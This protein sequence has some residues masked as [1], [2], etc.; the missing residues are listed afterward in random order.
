MYCTNCGEKNFRDEAFCKKCGEKIDKKDVKSTPS[1]NER[2][3][4]N[5]GIL[6]TFMWWKINKEELQTQVDNYNALGITQSV[7]GIS[8][9]LLIFSAIVSTGSIFFLNT[10]STAFVDVI[11]FLI[12]G[13]LIYKGHRWAIIVAMILWTCEKLYL[14]ATQYSSS[15]GGSAIIQ[16]FWWGLYMH[17]FYSA[18]RVEKLRVQEGKN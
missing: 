1:K 8:L 18:Y 5:F 2:K 15:S 13:Y 6:S 7:R 9:L 12:L 14:V 10:S 17:V 11:L 3:S 4:F 16:I